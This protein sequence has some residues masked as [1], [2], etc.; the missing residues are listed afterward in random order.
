[1]LI[2][3]AHIKSILSLKF[4]NYKAAVVSPLKHTIV[5]HIYFTKHRE[6]KT[7]FTS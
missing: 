7:T 1:M 3:Y 6:S 5:K 2:Y 4:N